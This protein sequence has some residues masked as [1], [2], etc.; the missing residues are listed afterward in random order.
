MS[1]LPDF[2]TGDLLLEGPE[3]TVDDGKG[4]CS[5]CGKRF[6]L[7]ANG[8]VRA[9][10]CDGTRSVAVNAK[11]V[12][13]RTA[14][15]TRSKGAPPSVRRMGVALLGAGIETMASVSVATYVPMPRS[16]IPE[17]VTTLPDADA[18]IGPVLDRLWPEVP[19]GMQGLLQRL[20]EQEDLIAAMFLWI[21]WSK[22]VK[23]YSVEMR[24]E[25]RAREKKAKGGSNVVPISRQVEPDDGLFP[26]PFQPVPDGGT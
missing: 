15:R 5:D 25:R 24:E 10:N 1:T 19:K 14:K 13:S 12:G 6:K 23:D 9:H 3:E 16:E 8:E 26:L 2:I 22:T 17:P 18:M 11:P 4:A 21:Q 20:A 7:K